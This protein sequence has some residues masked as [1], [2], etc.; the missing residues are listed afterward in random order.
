MNFTKEECRYTNFHIEN[1]KINFDGERGNLLVSVPFA[2]DTPECIVEKLNGM[3]YQEINRH[4]DSLK[5]V[6]IWMPCNWKPCNLVLNA[7]MQIQV[8]EDGGSFPQYYIAITI[9]DY[10]P[11]LSV[12]TWIDKNISIDSETPGFR[13]EF[14]I[15]CRNKVEQVL[16]PARY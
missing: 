4:L 9:T 16:F 5:G 10:L 3:V 14:M 13:N 8:S 11:E 12:G 7:G 15:Y 2:A 1:D 6:S